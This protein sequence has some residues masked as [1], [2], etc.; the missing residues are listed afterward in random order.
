MEN[1]LPINKLSSE[2]RKQ[3]RKFALLCKKKIWHLTR[4][5]MVGDHRYY[6]AD[7]RPWYPNTQKP[8]LATWFAGMPE[9]WIEL[10]RMQQ[11]FHSRLW[12]QETGDELLAY[13]DKCINRTKQWH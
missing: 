5:K 1:R 13:L 9:A 11:A 12:S 10:S 4:P 3:E 2:E 6:P 7:K 8:E